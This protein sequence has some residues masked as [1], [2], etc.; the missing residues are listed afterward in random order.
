MRLRWWRNALIWVGLVPVLLVLLFPFLVMTSTALTPMEELL[1]PSARWLPAHPR[2]QNFVDVFHQVPL[3]RHF[4]NSLII[5]V[6]ATLVSVG[7]AAP[8]AWALARLRFPGRSGFM[9]TVLVTQMFSPIVLIMALY[10]LMSGYG[11]LEGPRVYLSLILANG[12]FSLAF[13]V[14]LLTGYFSTV[15]AEVEEA[16]MIDGCTR[17]GT[18]RRIILPLSLPGIVTTVIFAFIA[19]WNEFMFALTLVGAK[20]YEPLTVGIYSFVER[21][22]TEWPY[23]CAASLMAVVPVV[24]L[25][26]AIE[27][28]LI[29]GLTAGAL[30]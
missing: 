12:A 24:V 8:A 27:R 21:Y 17:L 20:D 23:L 1:G 2:P 19:A 30:K 16:A 13:S 26:L 5:A 25:F 6:G 4:A 14:W 18:L 11:L 15:P 7:C 28:Q 9:F 3:A 10:R 22:G 29:R